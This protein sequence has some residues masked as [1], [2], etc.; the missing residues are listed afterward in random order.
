VT[1]NNILTPEDYFRLWAFDV[2]YRAYKKERDMSKRFV[3]AIVEASKPVAPTM[4]R[5]WKAARREIRRIEKTYAAKQIT[6]EEWA[7]Q[8]HNAILSHTG[9]E[10]RDRRWVGESVDDQI[11]GEISD[12]VV[13]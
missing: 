12:T 6:R 3:R 10:V 8:I 1:V 7:A 2:Y 11:P 13:A 9:V 4:V 5:A